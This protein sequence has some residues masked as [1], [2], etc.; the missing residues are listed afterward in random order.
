MTDISVISNAQF[1]QLLK[2]KQGVGYMMDVA[3]VEE[4]STATLSD[5]SSAP[6]IQLPDVV[7]VHN[8]CGQEDVMVGQDDLMVGQQDRDDVSVGRGG[9][10]DILHLNNQHID[11][12]GQVRGALR[13]LSLEEY[14]SKKQDSTSVAY[15]Q[16]LMLKLHEAESSFRKDLEAAEQT[17]DLNIQRLKYMAVEMSLARFE[18]YQK[19]AIAAGFITS[20]SQ[21]SA[22][23]ST[24]STTSVESSL[25]KIS[26]ID[27]GKPLDCSD[28]NW[29]LL[30]KWNAEWK[31]ERD[32]EAFLKI[33]SNFH[34]TIT[35]SG[36]R[37]F[38]EGVACQCWLSSFRHLGGSV[39]ELTTQIEEARS[40]DA[41][42]SCFKDWF[43]RSDCSIDAVHFESLVWQRDVPIA[44]FGQIFKSAASAKE[45]VQGQNTT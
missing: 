39:S 10:A 42:Q 21:P 25:V 35:R 15:E 36:K 26:S 28:I 12:S 13:R 29:Q 16:D 9:Q 41:M 43:T 34:T 38:A 40:W 23:S 37:P 6:E 3:Q 1:H 18:K 11:P 32:L 17:L 27:D 4:L 44:R 14:K 30:P 7:Y 22:S 20:P 31:K 2:Q 19:R 33:M 45:T 24:S 8:M 5:G